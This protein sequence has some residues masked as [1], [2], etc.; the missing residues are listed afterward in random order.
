[1]FRPQSDL[2]LCMQAGTLTKEDIVFLRKTAS[3][4]H[5]PSGEV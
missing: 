1:M 3:K 4:R 2:Y 5:I